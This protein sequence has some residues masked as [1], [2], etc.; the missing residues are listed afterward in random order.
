MINLKPYSV[1]S[2]IIQFL[3]EEPMAISLRPVKNQLIHYPAKQVEQTYL[4]S[5][6]P[7]F[8]KKFFYAIR[9]LKKP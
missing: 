8:S 6:W 5:K 1:K 2:L 7:F 3:L 4:E 9:Y